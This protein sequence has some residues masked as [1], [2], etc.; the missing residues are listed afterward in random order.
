MN[1]YTASP[2]RVTVK[3]KC[4][5]EYKGNLQNENNPAI[6]NWHCDYSYTFVIFRSIKK[7]GK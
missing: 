4:V 5:K 7:S 3:N 6:S 1:A 2:P